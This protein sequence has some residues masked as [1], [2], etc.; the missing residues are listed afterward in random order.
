[1]HNIV[2]CCVNNRCTILF[3]VVW[4]N[5]LWTIG[6]AQYCC[7]PLYSKLRIFGCVWIFR[8][9]F[10]KQHYFQFPT[11]LGHCRLRH[12]RARRSIMPWRHLFIRVH[13]RTLWR[14]WRC[15]HGH[16]FRGRR[17]NGGDNW[18]RR[19][20]LGNIHVPVG[21]KRKR[22]RNLVKRHNFYILFES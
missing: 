21:M 1:M 12:R 5:V 9:Q 11:N 7:N 17:G 4:T 18:S 16:G 22:M 13:H 8:E 14:H 15:C 6:A 3:N 10:Y 19:G 2:Q 20:C